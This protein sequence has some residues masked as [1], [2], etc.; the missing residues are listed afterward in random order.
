METNLEKRTPSLPKVEQVEPPKLPTLNELFD[1]V[2]S[3]GK[4]EGLNA[5][6]NVNP[7]EKWIKTH[8]TI[9]THRYLPI[10]KVEYL[11]RKIFKRYSIE[12]TGQGTA[13]NGVWVTVRVSYLDPVTGLMAFQDGIG[14]SQLQTKQGASPA[15]LANLNHG[16]ISMAFPIAKTLAIK[17]AC[18]LI[19]NIFGANIDRK[20][21]IAFE[22]DQKLIEKSREEIR[23][24]KLAAN[25]INV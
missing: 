15:D 19:G 18:Q 8:P 6:L 22:P 16:A 25:G 20:D 5:I 23:K 17:D 4:S 11:L 14:A 24:E 3:I 21:T 7:P 13:F 12:I 2:E 9:S 1:D 10:D